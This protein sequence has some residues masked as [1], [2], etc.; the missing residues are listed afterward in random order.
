[1]AKTEAAIDHEN[2]EFAELALKSL[3]EGVRRALIDHERRGF[4][5]PGLHQDK[6]EWISPRERLSLYPA[7]E[8]TRTQTQDAE[9]G[10]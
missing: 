1:M 7:P 2:A 6:I 3:K 4:L 5:V 10:N 8:R 9:Q